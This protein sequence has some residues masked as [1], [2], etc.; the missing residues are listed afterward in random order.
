MSGGAIAFS[1]MFDVAITIAQD[2][3]NVLN[4]NVP[5][6]LLTDSKGLFGV[7]SK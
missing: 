1:D 3:Q 4:Q 2:L 6:R 5:V 7:L